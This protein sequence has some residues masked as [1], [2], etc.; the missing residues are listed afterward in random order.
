MKTKT[1]L[2]QGIEFN[3]YLKIPMRKKKVK[4]MAPAIKFIF[5]QPLRESLIIYDKE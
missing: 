3:T 4:V 1:P 2:Q 5:S